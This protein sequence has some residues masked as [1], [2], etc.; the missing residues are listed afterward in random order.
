MPKSE[1]T[2]KDSSGLTPPDDALFTAVRE[3]DI[4]AIRRA[5]KNGAD[6]N[7][8]L[9]PFYGKCNYTPLHVAVLHKKYGAVAELLKIPSIDVNACDA[10][11]G[12]PLSLATTI[13]SEKIISL[14]LAHP[15]IKF[16][17]QNEEHKAPR[18]IAREDTT[19]NGDSIRSLFAK[20]EGTTWAQGEKSRGKE[21]W[22]YSKPSI[23]LL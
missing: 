16:D 11:G 4:N 8:R 2:P 20:H 23:T 7:A 3:D 10:W 1:I 18:D 17:I 5:I 21:P 19:Q 9:G 13:S 15:D 6:S 12:T 14:L 22:D